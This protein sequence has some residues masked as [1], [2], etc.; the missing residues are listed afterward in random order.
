[1]FCKLGIS[2]QILTAM[3]KK[4]VPPHQSCTTC[5]QLKDIEYG[6]QKYG[7]P[8]NDT[9]ISI[10]IDDLKAIKWAGS[11]SRERKLYQC[12]ICNTYYYYYT[13]Y[14]YLVNGSE[15]EQ[16][17]KRLTTAEAQEYLKNWR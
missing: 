15:D 13:D 6:Y 8:E 2:N 16:C 10:A 7:S 12:P 14:E 17:L 4:Q 9:F 11:S 3:S 1:M 5:K